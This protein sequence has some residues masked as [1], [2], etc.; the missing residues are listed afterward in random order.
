LAQRVCLHAKF[1][2]KRE[3][4]WLAIAV[5]IR[6]VEDSHL[7]RGKIHREAYFLDI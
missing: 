2:K 1:I 3:S 7:D 5:Q 4:V 6:A